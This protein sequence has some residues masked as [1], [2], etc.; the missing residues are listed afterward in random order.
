[1]CHFFVHGHKVVFLVSTPCLQ[2]T[3]EQSKLGLCNNSSLY[4]LIPNP[5][6]TF[7]FGNHKFVFYICAAAEA[8]SLQSCLTLCNPMDSSPPGSFVHGTL[9]ARIWEWVAISFSRILQPISVS[10]F[11][12][13]NKFICII[14]QTSHI[15]D[16]SIHVAANGIISFFL[17]LGSI[18]LCVYMYT[19]TMEKEMATH[20]SILAW[21]IPWMEE[22]GRPQSMKS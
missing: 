16:R 12:F 4:L 6:P 2:F 8:K 15:S 13:V 19:Y 17:W 20:S 7:L 11:Y 14:F 10:L 22:P 5:P 3:G 18:P 9:Q 21:E 1:M